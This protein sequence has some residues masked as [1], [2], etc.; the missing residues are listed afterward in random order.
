MNFIKLLIL[1]CVTVIIGKETRVYYYY[2][3]SKS[4]QEVDYLLNRNNEIPNAYTI[5]VYFEDQKLDH[6]QVLNNGN[7]TISVTV[8][9]PIHYLSSGNLH[10]FI[11]KGQCS[12]E[13]PDNALSGTILI[14][15][16]ITI[17]GKIDVEKKKEKVNKQII[18]QI[19]NAIEKK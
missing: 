19:I 17:A 5:N 4:R 18:E 3:L 11:F 16:K 7:Y 9:G 8:H 12:F 15:K 1:A 10:Q 14:D 13:T 2:S 6:K